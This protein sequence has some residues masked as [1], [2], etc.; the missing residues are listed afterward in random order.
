[1]F[2]L[3]HNKK[4]YTVNMLHKN[5]LSPYFSPL[6]KQIYAKDCVFIFLYV[7]FFFFFKVSLK[8][9]ALPYFV[10]HSYWTPNYC[11]VN[12][13]GKASSIKKI[14]LFFVEGAIAIFKLER[15]CNTPRGPLQKVLLPK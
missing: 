11:I 8:N 13:P 2:D 5:M 10:S 4:Y 1:M 6:L 7:F 12:K 15:Y 14:L 9:P 3:R